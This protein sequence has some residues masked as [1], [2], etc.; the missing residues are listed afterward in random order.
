MSLP[1][2]I[3]ASAQDHQHASSYLGTSPLAQEILARDIAECSSD[4]DSSDDEFAFDGRSLKGSTAPL[5]FHPPGVAY[6][7]CQRPALGPHH[8]P[9]H[10][11]P[12]RLDIEESRNAERS[13]LRDNH[14]LPPKHARPSY[15]TPLRR[16]YRRL[17][18]TKVRDD[19]D[20]GPRLTEISSSKAFETTPLLHHVEE[21]GPPTP[22]ETHNRFEAAAAANIL[23]T[24][25]QRE[26]KTLLQYSGPLIITFLLHYSVTIG[27]VLTVGRIGMRELG[28]VNCKPLPIPSSSIIT[29]MLSGNH[30]CYH[31]G[32]H[33]HSGVGHKP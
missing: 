13:L 11:F 28:A 2:D 3:Q 23:R 19:N 18:S 20:F 17:F 21:C 10:V 8:D 27:S 14:I 16:L 9:K 12:T 22:N 26:A 15:E 4:G 7:A 25:W 1:I 32:L 33:S 24:T 30:D 6:G 31:Y 5:S 29:D